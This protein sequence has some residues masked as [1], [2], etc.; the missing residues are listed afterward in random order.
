MEE[1]LK[2]LNLPFDFISAVDGSKLSTG[3][4]KLYSRKDALRCTGRELSRGEIGCALSHAGMWQRM[5]NEGIDE[6]LIL[7]DDVVLGEMFIRVLQD[8]SRLPDD[9]ELINFMTD[10]PQLPIG[11]P[12][13]DIYRVCRFEG[14]A[15][16]TGAYLINRRGAEKLLKHVFP[17]RWPAD[18]L[19][20]RTYI[21]GLVSYGIEPRLLI[22]N[23][24]ESDI[25]KNGDV[26]KLET[27]LRSKRNSVLRKVINGLS[28][29]CFGNQK[30]ER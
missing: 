24:F 13:C 23:H 7:E 20:G 27:S 12:V 10:V 3:E 19:T 2:G 14:F 16:R 5:M 21:T 25:W 9:W 28:Y 17:V 26:L 18:G 4:L 22:L 30:L 15:N 1:Q 8:R 11:Q 6:V 29:L